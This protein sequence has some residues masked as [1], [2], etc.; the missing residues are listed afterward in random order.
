MLS[1]KMKTALI[2]L[3]LSAVTLTLAIGSAQYLMHVA[4]LR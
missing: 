3:M 2:F 4:V 1:D